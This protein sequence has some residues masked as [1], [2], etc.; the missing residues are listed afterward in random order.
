MNFLEF[1]LSSNKYDIIFLVETFL[2]VD[3]ELLYDSIIKNSFSQLINKPT[4][5][6]NIIDLLFT[7]E[8]QLLSY[9]N[10]GDYFRL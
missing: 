1:L 9:I 7:N 10:I 4:I 8:K 3:Y 2:T 6:N 5:N